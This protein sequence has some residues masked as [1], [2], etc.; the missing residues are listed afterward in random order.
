ML[1]MSFNYYTYVDDNMH[2]TEEN[3]A[4]TV[5]QYSNFYY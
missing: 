4:V 2:N 1:I 5:E 3:C